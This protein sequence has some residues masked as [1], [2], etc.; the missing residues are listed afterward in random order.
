MSLV[1]GVDLQ[2]RQRMTR[3]LLGRKVGW[4]AR[5]HLDRENSML[6]VYRPEGVG[7]VTFVDYVLFTSANHF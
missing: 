4:K 5:G 6:Q 1:S 7:R 2:E 3:D